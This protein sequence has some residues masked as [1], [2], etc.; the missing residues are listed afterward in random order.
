LRQ[1]L[2]EVTAHNQELQRQ[3]QEAQR[4]LL[5]HISA[6]SLQHRPSPSEKCEDK[7]C[8]E[9]VATKGVPPALETSTKGPNNPIL[10]LSCKVEVPE[11]IRSAERGEEEAVVDFLDRGE[12]PNTTDDMGLT[13]L[14]CASKKGRTRVVEVLLERRANTNLSSRRSET[15]L[16]YACKYGHLPIVQMLIA[17]RARLDA[18]T[19]QQKTPIQ[20]AR[21]NKHEN[22]VKLLQETAEN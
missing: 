20:Y 7:R 9:M 22:I 21:D 3:L 19:E 2:Q 10:Q 1:Q 17:S 5:V 12:D 16:H 6:E 14:H 11:M 13:A 8:S 18:E 15:P 4:Q